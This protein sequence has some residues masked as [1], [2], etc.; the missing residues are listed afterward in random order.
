MWPGAITQQSPLPRY[1]GDTTGTYAEPITWWIS[2]SS[3]KKPFSLSEFIQN[4]QRVT[5]AWHECF[6]YELARRCQ[7]D[8]TN[9]MLYNYFWSRTVEYVMK[10]HLTVDWRWV[11][12]RWVQD[13]YAN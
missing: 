10:I 7:R 4:K 2:G 9:M 11:F 13:L 3:K 8:K 12:K 5:E 1:Y 6:K